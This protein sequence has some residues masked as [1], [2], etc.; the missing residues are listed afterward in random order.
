LTVHCRTKQQMYKGQ[1]DWSWLE[2]IRKV[3]S[4]PLI[5]NGDVTGP[6]EAQVLLD[7]GCDGVMVGRAAL[8][9]PWVF[10]QIKHFLSTG[11]RLPDI[12]LSERIR[13]CK[14]H[15]LY[16]TQYQGTAERLYA[17]RKFYGGYFRDIP[18]A[19]KLRTELMK[20][21]DSPGIERALTEFL[22]DSKTQVSEIAKDQCI[23]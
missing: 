20:Q 4:I 12:D 11:T 6:A 14:K 3:I 19:Q 18:N 21:P 8:H 17:F 13:V 23:C 15:L 9:N 22:E 1:A 16:Y 5:G 10:K 7:S 2:R